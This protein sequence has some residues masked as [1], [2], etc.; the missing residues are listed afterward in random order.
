METT[1]EFLHVT[2][3]VE[4]TGPLKEFYCDR[5]G[6]PLDYEQPGRLA[7]LGPGAHDLHEGDVSGSARLCFLADDVAAIAAEAEGAGVVGTTE[8]DGSGAP[9]W[10]ATDPA[11]H[12]VRV[13][14]KPH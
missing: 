11:G 4:D 8:L 14:T 13:V 2:F 10:T 6:Q 5:V 1:L 9:M 7:A 3:F 12:S